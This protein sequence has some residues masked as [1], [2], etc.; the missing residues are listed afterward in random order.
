MPEALQC[1]CDGFEYDFEKRAP[2]RSPCSCGRLMC[3]KCASVQA[4]LPGPGP[5]HLCGASAVG[6]FDMSDFTRDAGTLAAMLTMMRKTK[7]KVFM[8]RQCIDCTS[9]GYHIV[10]KHTCTDV[11]CDLKPLCAGHAMTHEQWGHVIVAHV[12]PG[13]EG[14]EAEK[15]GTELG[16][17]VHVG[18]TQCPER[19]HKHSVGGELTNYCLHCSTL[20]CRTCMDL[21]LDRHHNVQSMAEAAHVATESLHAA[22][23][24]LME[25][26]EFHKDQIFSLAAVDQAL[27]KNLE[28]ARRDFAQAFKFWH[29]QVDAIYKVCCSKLVELHAKKAAEVECCTKRTQSALADIETAVQVA[30]VALEGASQNPLRVLAADTVAKTVFLACRKDGHG[31]DPTLVGDCWNV[32]DLVESIAISLRSA[33]LTPQGQEAVLQGLQQGVQYGFAAAKEQ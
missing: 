20:V 11:M 26:R 14:D 15:E 18:I 9:A 4:S 21:H 32:E 25:S 1:P 22:L 28:R 19:H 6:P 30:E 7:P 2:M 33:E 27:H 10:A 17:D 16:P 3:R 24:A 12:F 29:E 5:C 13:E 8:D 31:I 23:P